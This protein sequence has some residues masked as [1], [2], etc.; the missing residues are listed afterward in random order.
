MAISNSADSPASDELVRPTRDEAFSS[1]VPELPMGTRK[2]SA[3]LPAANAALVF[4]CVQDANTST[5]DPCKMSRSCGSSSPGAS[6]AKCRV[7]LRTRQLGLRGSKSTATSSSSGSG[8]LAIRAVALSIT[9]SALRV[10]RVTSGSCA[11]WA[12]RMPTRKARRVPAAPARQHA[13]AA[14]LRSTTKTSTFC[15]FPS[16]VVIIVRKDRGMDKALAARKG[17]RASQKCWRSCSAWK[18]HELSR[19]PLAWPPRSASSRPSVR[20][21]VSPSDASQQVALDTVSNIDSWASLSKE[22]WHWRSRSMRSIQTKSTE[23][24]PM[25]ARMMKMTYGGTRFKASMTSMDGGCW[26][27]PPDSRWDTAFS[28]AEMPARELTIKHIAITRPSLATEAVLLADISGNS[29]SDCTCKGG[30]VP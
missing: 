8:S 3:S 11:V 23:T 10:G 2:V 1:M 19:R 29:R 28:R 18:M 24:A 9:G 26:F 13:A 27:L 7:Q 30:A 21:M 14:V 12:V 20:T 6:G 5:P 16:T 15:L 4:S 17:R 25:K 22:S